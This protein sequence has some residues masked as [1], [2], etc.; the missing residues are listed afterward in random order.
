MININ[1]FVDF[2]KHISE[3]KETSKSDNGEYMID[4]TLPVINFDEVKKEYNKNQGLDNEP[5]S[6]DALYEDDSGEQYFIE[7]K[8]GK[9]VGKSTKHE[10]RRIRL[11]MLDSPLIFTD[12][13][14]KDAS[15]TKKYIN[16][17]VVYNREK[18]PYNEEENMFAD[19]RESPSMA[20]IGNY[21]SEKAKERYI[22][23]GL[24]FYDEKC[25]KGVFTVNED[26]FIEK[27]V[28]KWE[29]NPTISKGC[30]GVITH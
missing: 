9:L 16:F 11:K 8:S 24:T 25:F 17:I 15:Y 26:E 30:G 6:A 22:R 5:S 1:E 7:F 18:N 13:I 29:R 4:S 21:F 27:F 2:K 14:N 12:I 3:L 23:F 10:K 20:N 19:L 28:E